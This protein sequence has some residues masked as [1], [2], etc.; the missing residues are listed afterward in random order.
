MGAE[1]QAFSLCFAFYLDTLT[2]ELDWKLSIHHSNSCECRYLSCPL[3]PPCHNSG[4]RSYDFYLGDEI[5]V[6]A[7]KEERLYLFLNIFSK[8]CV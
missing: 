2:G 1:T 5:S 6:V 7:K 8:M 3:N 4:P